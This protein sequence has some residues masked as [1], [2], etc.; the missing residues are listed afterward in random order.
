[1]AVRLEE[2]DD[3]TQADWEQVV[4]GEPEPF[5]AVG[6]ELQ[7][8]RKSR[9]LGLRDDAGALVGLAG[10]VLAEARV[11]GA[12]LQ[13]AGIGGVIVTRAARGGGLARV[14]I[15]RVLEIAPELGAELAMLF[16]LPANVGLYAKFGFELIETPVSARQPGGVIEVPMCAMWRP[17]TSTARWP[18]G[19]IELTGEPF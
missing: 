5:G 18:P 12:P 17:L 19:S 15:E 16:C 11:D 4:A 7:W 6:E 9:Y 3:I 2:L 13:V 14:L 8:R 10:V 1:V